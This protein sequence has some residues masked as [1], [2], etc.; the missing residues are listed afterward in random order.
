MAVYALFVEY[1]Y[2]GFVVWEGGEKEI[3]RV[4]ERVHVRPG[5]SS[6]MFPYSQSVQSRLSRRR[7]IA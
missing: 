4:N 1:C 3:G 2:A 7:C 5:S 6:R